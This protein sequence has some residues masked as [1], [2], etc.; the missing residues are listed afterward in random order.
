[1][2]K[3]GFT[4]TTSNNNPQRNQPSSAQANL[5]AATASTSSQAATSA[6][7]S[8]AALMGGAGSN[9]GPIE[10]TIHFCQPQAIVW[11]IKFI[12]TSINSKQAL[13]LAANELE[14]V[15][16]CYTSILQRLLY[17]FFGFTY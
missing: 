9:Q 10:R 6:A 4:N 11:Q 7:T 2:H 14:S 5:A 16:E 13:N 12:L 17:S 8:S 3:S 15:S 1:M